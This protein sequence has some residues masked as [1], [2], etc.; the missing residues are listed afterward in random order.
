MP[1]SQ[2]GGRL[3]AFG[4]FARSGS[5]IASAPS[6]ARPAGSA[7]CSR[8]LDGGIV[9]SAT[10]GYALGFILMALVALACLLVLGRLRGSRRRMRA[11][12][13]TSGS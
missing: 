11:A 1:I 6:R 8:R 5:R 3:L 10:G 2:A 4:G 13:P 9:K 7:A 12:V